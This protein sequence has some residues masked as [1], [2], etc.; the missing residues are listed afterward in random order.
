MINLRAQIE[1][2]LGDS[3]ESEWKMPVEL[4]GPDGITQ[5]YSVNNPSALL[6]G[7]ILYFTQ[8][9]NP[10][11]GETIIVNKP[12]VSLRISS[13]RRVPQSG[14]KWYIKMPVSPIAGAI[15]KDYVFTPTRAIEDGQDIGF[16]RIYPQKMEVDSE[17]S[18]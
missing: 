2:D 10:E 6:G 1:K 11:T 15:K 14:E 13:L 9:I 5:K 3:I 12:V 18:S 8:S 16:I 4:T 17:V 7:Q